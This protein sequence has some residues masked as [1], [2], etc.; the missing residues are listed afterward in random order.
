M[1]DFLS[2]SIKSSTFV[3]L[4]LFAS[5]ILNP[6]PSFAKGNSITKIYSHTEECLRRKRNRKYYKFLLSSKL[7]SQYAWNCFFKIYTFFSILGF[8]LIILG[9]QLVGH[10]ANF[11]KKNSALFYLA[12]LL[13]TD[14]AQRKT[15]TCTHTTKNRNKEYA[16]QRYVWN[17]T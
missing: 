7:A 10:Y 8:I 16:N 1:K 2:F 6:L 9:T 11:L 3:L 17:S 4:F 15:H 5:L 14:I 12:C 13:S